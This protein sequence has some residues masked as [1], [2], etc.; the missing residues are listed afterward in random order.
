M[1]MV[2][3][4]GLLPLI[5]GIVLLGFF[6]AKAARMRG[7]NPWVWGIFTVAVI[8]AV[9]WQQLPIWAETV[10]YRGKIK[11]SIAPQR[12]VVNLVEAN[13]INFHVSMDGV[14]PT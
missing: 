5:L 12:K 13:K 8:T 1:I 7:K 6:V 10:F 11:Q 2:F 3:K 9:T 14:N 4:I